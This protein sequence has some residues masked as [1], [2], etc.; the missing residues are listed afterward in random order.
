MNQ[1]IL[2]LDTDFIPYELRRNPIKMF[3]INDIIYSHN[4]FNYN[5]SNGNV[6]YNNID[7]EIS[8]KEIYDSCIIFN[9]VWEDNY[10]HFI[11]DNLLPIF[12]LICTYEKNLYPNNNIIL[13]LQRK[14][15]LPINNKWCE[16]LK[17]FV[18]DVRYLNENIFMKEGILSYQVWKQPWKSKIN[19]SINTIKFLNNFRDIIYKKLKL[20]KNDNPK[21]I[22]F[23]SR[24]NAKWRKVLNEDDIKYN[25]IS[26]ENISLKEEV[27]IMNNTKIFITPYGAG[28]VSGFFLNKNSTILIIYPPNFSYTRDCSTMEIDILNKLDINVICCTNKCEIIETIIYENNITSNN[29]LKYRD[30]NFNIN[31]NNLDKIV[32]SL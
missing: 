24:K 29:N 26:F 11:L 16:L 27:N 2:E 6:Q 13:Y 18:S 3:I 15:H 20:N 23:L 5:I 10:G 1:N 17:C 14:S 31:I 28:L 12:K 22:N 25:K 8:Y 32:N 19:N 4:K 21:Q 7:K 9:Q 30:E